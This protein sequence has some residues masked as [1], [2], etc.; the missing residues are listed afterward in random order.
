MSNLLNS[1]IM[2]WSHLK[3]K[4]HST[5]V[6]VCVVFPSTFFLCRN[7]WVYI[8]KNPATMYIQYEILIRAYFWHYMNTPNLVRLSPFSTSN[9]KRKQ[10][11]GNVGGKKSRRTNRNRSY[12]F[13]CSREQMYQVE[14]GHQAT[15]T[16][17]WFCCHN[18]WQQN[19]WN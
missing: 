10:E 8:T 9:A 17:V 16:K 13:F 15:Q 2:T 7:M 18:K 4:C 6:E 11:F 3:L 12:Y 5:L 14:I 1:V 19:C